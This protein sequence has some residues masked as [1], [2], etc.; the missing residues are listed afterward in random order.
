ML[1]L[2]MHAK[3]MDVTN[4]IVEHDVSKAENVMALMCRHEQ[5][6][7]VCNVMIMIH[8]YGNWMRAKCD[9]VR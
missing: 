5:V 6:A 7:T 3:K 4:I 2:L 1:N 9:G 8:D